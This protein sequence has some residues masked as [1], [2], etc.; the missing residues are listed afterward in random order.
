YT[1]FLSLGYS[2]LPSSSQLAVGHLRTLVR[3][4]DWKWK[5]NLFDPEI[6]RA[7]ELHFQLWDSEFDKISICALDDIWRNSE[8]A[9]F[10]AISL[11]VLSRQHNL[12][13]CILH[14]FR[15]LLRNDLRLSHL[16]EIGYFLQRRRENASF[17][18][19]FLKSL[20]SCSNSC[21]ATATM[22]ELARRTFSAEPE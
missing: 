16:Y 20:L 6:P 11:P 13:Y 7:V 14:S 2:P 15:H 8:V 19:G 22:L 9:T 10:E 17:W 12:L 5:G 3:T 1:L 4:T 21:R 18:P